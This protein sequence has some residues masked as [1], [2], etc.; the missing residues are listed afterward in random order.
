LVSSPVVGSAGGSKL[1]IPMTLDSE[2]SRLFTS[3]CESPEFSVSVN[4]F[5]DPV[6]A[7]IVFDG[8]VSNVNTDD[9]EV[10]VGTVLCN[11][12]R[13]KNSEATL[14]RNISNIK[15]TYLSSDSLLSNGSE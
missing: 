11:P 6:D 15:D 1:V 3:G 14:N 7:W 2:S 12:I 4:G 9:F 8:I 13:V 10:L 5:T